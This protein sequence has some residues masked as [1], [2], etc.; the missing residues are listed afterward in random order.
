MRL[1]FTVMTEGGALANNAFAVTDIIVQQKGNSV[2]RIFALARSAMSATVS[3]INAAITA[4]N[5]AIAAA[6][7]A[8]SAVR[9][10]VATNTRDIATLKA[11]AFS[12]PMALFNFGAVLIEK[13]LAGAII[14]K[15]GAQTRAAEISFPDAG[16]NLVLRNATLAGDVTVNHNATT[17]EQ[18]AAVTQ[19][20]WMRVGN[21]EEYALFGLPAD[22]VL[23]F[24]PDPDIPAPDPTKD[25]DVDRTPLMGIVGLASDFISIGGN[26]NIMVD[27]LGAGDASGFIRLTSGEGTYVHRDKTQYVMQV[28]LHHDANPALGGSITPIAY[29]DDGTHTVLTQLND[30]DFHKPLNMNGLFPH[31]H[32]G[33]TESYSERFKILTGLPFQRHSDLANMVSLAPETPVAWGARVV[34]PGRAIQA[35]NEGFEFLSDVIVPEGKLKIRKA[36][37]TLEDFSGGSFASPAFRYV[38]VA[39]G[40]AAPTLAGGTPGKDWRGG[41][42]LKPNPSPGTAERCSARGP[43]RPIMPPTIITNS[44]PMWTP[45]RTRR[46]SGRITE[47]AT[48]RKIRRPQQAD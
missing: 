37:G 29:H 32:G 45:P 34:G 23:G 47:N 36:D 18:R 9:A 14:R 5:A 25:Q 21:D 31:T 19:L 39:H 44:A 42:V 28:S 1:V 26:G 11:N 10:S 20:T 22:F 43:P 48:G 30:A 7:T 27:N 38:R 35:L 41:A 4:A 2:D 6:N 15:F 24:I 8:I 40:V 33:F 46:L 12:L 3:G 13:H 16:V 17:A